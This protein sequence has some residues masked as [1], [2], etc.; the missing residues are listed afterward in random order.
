MKILL[1]NTFDTIGGPGRWVYM[2]HQNFL[3]AKIDSVYLADRKF[4]NDNTVLGTRGRLGDLK[5]RMKQVVDY[6]PLIFYPDWKKVIFSTGWAPFDINQTIKKIKPD[7]VHLNWI[8]R[9]FVNI[10]SLQNIGVPIVWTMHDMW[11]FTGGCHYDE[12]CGRF[13][14]GC[15][16]CPILGS[17]STSD[18][19]SSILNKKKKCWHNIDLTM[20]APSH[21]LYNCAKESD[22][23]KNTRVEHLPVGM[24]LTIYTPANKAE[25]RKILGLPQDKKLVLFGAVNA[26]DDKR[27]GFKY[28]IDALKNLSNQ[29]DRIELAV[30]GSLGSDLVSSIGFKCHFLGNIKDNKKIALVYSAADVLV[31]PSLQDNMPATVMESL[32]CGT[33]VVA[34]NIGGMSDMIEHNKNGYLARPFEPLDLA[35][36]ISIIINSQDYTA[37][38]LRSRKKMEEE[39]N[40]GTIADRYIALYKDVLEK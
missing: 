26:V 38:S 4:S 28:L 27:K 24:D 23:F 33:P 11:P 16:K 20:V 40:I 12:E 2:M 10:K 18:L 21:W 37:L 15:G 31:A 7:I 14:M 30:F 32:A 19:S 39:Y 22:L 8:N 3:Q 29:Q 34:F 9:G 5:S 13:K 25:A 6:F 17:S 35:S 36:G 1:V